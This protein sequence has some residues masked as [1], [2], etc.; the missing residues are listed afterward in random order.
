MTEIV[1]ELREMIPLSW[2]RVFGPYI[3]YLVYWFRTRVR[4]RTW[5][6]SVL[7]SSDTLKKIAREELSVIR[8]G[9]G[10]LSL[11]SGTNLGFQ[12]YEDR[13]SYQLKEII[14]GNY[15]GLLICIPNIFDRLEHLTKTGFW[16]EIHHL[17]RYSYLWKDLTAPN[18][19]YGDAFI[20]RPYLSYKN[21]SGAANV[22]KGIK[23][24]WQNKKVVLIEGEKSRLGVGN[25]LF[26][27]ASS[28]KRILAPA[29][30]AFSKSSEI[31]NE[32][33]KLSKDHL[34]LVSLGPAAKIITYELFKSGYR[35]IDIGHLDMEY[36]MFLRQAE[37]LAPVAGKYFNEI[38]ER[39]PAECH[40][41]VYKSQIIATIV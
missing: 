12:K 16:F 31:I 28:L 39:D 35:V 26:A 6:P 40:D 13:L 30:N 27:E 2:R 25:D 9:D 24:I 32:A 17:F 22:L 21:R 10:E 37:N 41:P 33:N 36:E 1:P 18:R 38:N 7:S 11:I 34:I 15:P 5:E 8:F 29:E 14:R 23:N 4:G 3:G 19:V 20:T